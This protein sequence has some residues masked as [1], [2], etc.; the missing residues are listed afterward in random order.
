MNLNPIFVTLFDHD[1]WPLCPKC[2]HELRTD[3]LP[4]DGYTQAKPD[5]VATCYPLDIADLAHL[6]MTRPLVCNHCEWRTP[7]ALDP[8]RTFNLPR[9]LCTTEPG[10]TAHD[11]PGLPLVKLIIV[12]FDRSPMDPGALVWSYWFGAN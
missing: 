10:W 12:K 2:Q 5:H 4:I 7:T 11:Y 3:T 9:C 1:G 8:L 6:A